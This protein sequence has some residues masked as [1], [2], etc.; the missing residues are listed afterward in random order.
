MPVG[1][2]M[3]NSVELRPRAVLVTGGAGYI[4]SH[5]AYALSC[6]GYNVIIIDDFSQQQKVQLPFAT[7][8]AG[9]FADQQ[10]LNQIFTAY[11]IEAVFHFAA[12]IEVGE[13]VKR[14]RLFYE[15][16]VAKTGT[17]LGV[18]LDHGVRRFIFSSS[19]AVYGEPQY[20]PMDEKHPTAPV[21]PYGKTK[22]AVE[23]ILQDYAQAYGLEYAALRYFNA[24]GALWELGLGEQ[25][26]PETH[27][28]PRV[29]DAIAAGEEIQVF[30]DAY[31][32]ADG[33]CLRD[34]IHVQDLAQVHIRAFK[35]LQN[36]QESL[37][38]NVGTGQGHTVREVI[39]AAEQ[40]CRR[41]ALVRVVAPRAGDAPVLVANTMRM[42][43]V[44]NWQPQHSDL[45]A[46]I[47]SAQAWQRVRRHGS[48]HFAS[49]NTHHD[50]G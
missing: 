46:I 26:T 12:F 4:G 50:L 35:Y 30:G 17:L 31:A 5:T 32:T 41:S 33:T 23:F 11:D 3:E 37:V 21:S 45:I 40:V 16:N 34:Y 15:N 19:C 9:D 1:S 18:M 10:I 22:L 14:P 49:Q 6:E 38:L 44:L 20:L 39:K 29:L 47:R 48:I 2:S 8:V 13:S 27:L 7:V 24:A 25:H 42:R 28:I 43:E 36:K